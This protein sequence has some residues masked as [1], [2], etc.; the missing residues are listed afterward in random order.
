M[1][2]YEPAGPAREYAALALNYYKG[3]GHSCG[4]CY[5]PGFLGMLSG[6]TIDHSQLGVVGKA[7]ATIPQKI[8]T[9]LRK[10]RRAAPNF[11]GRTDRVLLSFTSDPYQ[12]L[13]LELRLTRQVLQILGENNVLV[14]VLTKNP[15]LALEQDFDLLKRYKTEV[16]TTIVFADDS[17]RQK[18]EPNTCSI[19]DRVKALEDCR[20]AGLKTWVS[21][22][23]IIDRAEV[24]PVIELLSGKTDLLKIGVVDP[25]WN[26]EEH[27][28][29]DW[30]ILLF[31]IFTKLHS[32]KQPYY[33]K[34][35]L[36]RYST[37][38]LRDKFDK[39]KR[40]F[41]E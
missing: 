24:I 7:K 35:G 21:V 20:A 15:K 32:L 5:V 9:F 28:N 25:R 39:E 38:E 2:I 12:L 18:W 36:W 17:K 22:E 33:I 30:S 11:S 14:T 3:C 6:T 26:P 23:P 27:A 10:L 34:D 31:E 16:A 29:I 40:S 8:A 13:E 19:N 37:T 1:P 4:Y 41:S